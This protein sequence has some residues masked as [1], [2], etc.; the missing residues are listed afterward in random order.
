MTFVWGLLPLELT[1]TTKT[2]SRSY[3]LGLYTSVFQEGPNTWTALSR[4]SNS[5]NGV[6]N[7][8]RTVNPDSIGDWRKKIANHD[9]ATTSL[10]AERFES[11]GARSNGRVDLNSFRTSNGKQAE[12]QDSW[13]ANSDSVGAS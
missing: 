12:G 8:T 7:E 1:L 6:W 9:S 2:R 11:F 4:H 5:K 3:D 13:D 10:Y